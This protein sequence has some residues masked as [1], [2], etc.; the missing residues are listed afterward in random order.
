MKLIDSLERRV[1]IEKNDSAKVDLLNY[2]AELNKNRDLN[3]SLNQATHALKIARKIDYKKG[4]ATALFLKAQN[5]YNASNDSILWMAEKA[6][7]YSTAINYHALTQQIYQLLSYYY[8]DNNN[9][10]KA[11]EMNDLS[12]QY[13]IS[14]EDRHAL[15]RAYF[16]YGNFYA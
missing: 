16:S 10:L 1:Q 8:Y 13:A 2:L 7:D 11:K 15:V 3:L 9:L 12:M 14:S 5:A 6:L 4:I